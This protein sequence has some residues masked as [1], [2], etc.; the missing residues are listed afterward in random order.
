MTPDQ[1]GPESAPD[2]ASHKRAS[3]QLWVLGFLIVAI[4]F[5]TA[6]IYIEVSSL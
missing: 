1:T 4:S 3:W 6:A 5:A 2:A